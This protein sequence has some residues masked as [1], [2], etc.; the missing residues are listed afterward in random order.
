MDLDNCSDDD[1]TLDISATSKESPTSDSDSDSDTS[2]STG[3]TRSI[4]SKSS[5]GNTDLN[6]R[7]ENTDLGGAP[8][9]LV[10]GGDRNRLSIP[11]NPLVKD[12]KPKTL[13]PHSQ[14]GDVRM[15]MNT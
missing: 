10:N 2:S 12:V 1:E 13:F 8:R 11:R 9:L 3:M 7:D 4:K 6:D 15:S 14:E 5:Y